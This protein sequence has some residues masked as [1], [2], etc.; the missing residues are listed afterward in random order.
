MMFQCTNTEVI[1]LDLLCDGTN[2]CAGGQD[3]VLFICESKL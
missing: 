1:T 2:Q 3:E